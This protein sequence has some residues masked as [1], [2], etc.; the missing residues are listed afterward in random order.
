MGEILGLDPRWTL[1][2]PPHGRMSGM[3]IVEAMLAPETGAANYVAP[4]YANIGRSRR[5]N[6]GGEEVAD[7]WDPW[8]FTSPG[9]AHAMMFRMHMERHGTATRQLA[10]VSVAFRNHA[11]L[12][13]DAVMKKPITI[14][15]HE[16]AREDRARLARAVPDPCRRRL[17]PTRRRIDRSGRSIHSSWIHRT[18]AGWIVRSGS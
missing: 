9:A 5:I 17:R 15:D 7:V 12:N 1:P 11:I 3:A 13:P 14:E 16:T 2:M 18:I 6:Y 4:L 10:E 8:G